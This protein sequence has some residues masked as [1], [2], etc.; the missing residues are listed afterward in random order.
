MTAPVIPSTLVHQSNIR[1]SPICIR[2]GAATGNI[3]SSTS[4]ML[5]N[6]T[7]QN[8]TSAGAVLAMFYYDP[9]KWNIGT[10]TTNWVLEGWAFTTGTAVSAF[11]LAFRV[12]QVTAISSRVPTGISVISNTAQTAIAATANTMYDV[13]T[14]PFASPVAGFYYI[15]L[16]CIIGAPGQIMDFGYGVYLQYA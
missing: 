7:T 16:D 15:Q 1:T 12:L 2:T 3:S 13:A 4:V 6:G 10:Y 9:N 8:D 5:P 14:S 11:T